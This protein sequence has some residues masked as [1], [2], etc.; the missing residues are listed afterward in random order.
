MLLAATV[1]VSISDDASPAALAL[2]IGEGVHLYE[3][4]ATRAY[5]LL[6]EVVA[7]VREYVRVRVCLRCA[8]ACQ[9]VG[10]LFAECACM[11]MRLPMASFCSG[12]PVSCLIEGCT[13]RQCI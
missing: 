10:R 12:A 7:S 6:S 3:K 13:S 5:R 11:D 4:H 1:P 8:C 9:L 2:K